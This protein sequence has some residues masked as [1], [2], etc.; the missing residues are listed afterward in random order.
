MKKAENETEDPGQLFRVRRWRINEC[1]PPSP[2]KENVMTTVGSQSVVGPIK[3]PGAR[4]SATGVG[5]FTELPVASLGSDGLL[6]LIHHNV[7]R[8]FSYNKDILRLSATGVQ[9][10]DGIP[11]HRQAKHICQGRLTT[12]PFTRHI[13]DSLV[14]TRLQADIPHSPWIDMIPFPR[15]RDNLILWET[16]FDHGEFLRDLVGSVVDDGQL[17]VPWRGPVQPLAEP[18]AMTEPSM[19]TR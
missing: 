12:L 19:M 11:Q 16:E 10:S 3:K 18:A 15:L 9:V 5:V 8:A 17:M 6:H 14:P 7:L 2:A 1:A 4:S 13:P